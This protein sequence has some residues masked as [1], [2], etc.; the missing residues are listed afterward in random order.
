MI[1]RINI[2]FNVAK[3][4]QLRARALEFHN[5]GFA[6]SEL[7]FKSLAARPLFFVGS[8]Y[9]NDFLAK[10]VSEIQIATTSA[11]GRTKGRLTPD[12]LTPWLPGDKPSIEIEAA[13]GCAIG[14]S[15]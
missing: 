12:L 15:R 6:P 1:C 13:A 4:R 2:A 11:E 3:C 5:T 7:T 8:P 10:V 9:R 14:S